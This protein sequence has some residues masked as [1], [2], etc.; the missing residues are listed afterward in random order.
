MNQ[1]IFYQIILYIAIVVTKDFND[2]LVMSMK[3]KNPA[4]HPCVDIKYPKEYEG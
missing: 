1:R 4:D 3:I 2:K